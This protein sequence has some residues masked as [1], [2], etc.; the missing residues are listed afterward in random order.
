M[1]VY[2]TVGIPFPK[3]E[4]AFATNKSVL[5]LIRRIEHDIEIKGD[6]E[7][8][9]S[10]IRSVTKLLEH[11]LDIISKL[12]LPEF[13]ALSDGAVSHA[14]HLY[15][16]AFNGN[17]RRRRLDAER[18]FKCASCELKSAHQF[19]DGFRNQHFAHA[20]MRINEHTLHVL[21]SKD[22]MTPITNVRSQVR[23]TILCKSYKWSHLEEAAQFVCKCLTREI[24]ENARKLDAKL[25][26]QQKNLVNSMNRTGVTSLAI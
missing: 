8:C 20:E 14:V 17:S 18:Y 15:A 23:R 2:D 24:A 10:A 3:L 12:G 5:M 1:T 13:Y 4:P 11:E 9:I 7:E 22:G 6:L 19:F 25:T 16:K 26:M 21:P